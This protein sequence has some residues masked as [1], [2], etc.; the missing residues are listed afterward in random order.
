M[1][2]NCKIVV[3]GIFASFLTQSYL[4]AQTETYTVE[5]AP[6]SSKKY[7]EFSPVYYKNGIVFCANMNQ[8]LFVSYSTS[9]NKSLFKI[10]FVEPKE[11]NNWKSVELF[12]KELKS[13][14]NDGPVTFNSS[15][16]EIYFSRNIEENAGSGN[17]SRLRSRLGLFSSN[18]VNGKW[19]EIKEFRFNNEYYSVTTPSLSPDGKRI[20][21]ASDKPGGFGGSDLYY[22]DRLNDY[23]DNPVNLGPVIN[24]AGNESYP[25]INSA[26][27]LFFSSDGHA[28]LGGKDIFFSRFADSVWLAPVALD[29]PINSKWDDFGITTNPEMGEGYFSSNRGTKSLDIYYFKTNFQQQFYS[30]NQRENQYC[31]QFNDDKSVFLDSLYLVFEWDFGDGTKS[32]GSNVVHCF[33]GPGMYSVRQNILDKNTGRNLFTKLAYNLEIRDVE[34]PYINAVDLALVGDSIHI[35]GLK[36]NIPGFSI[37]NYSWDFGDGTRANGNAV[38]HTYSKEGE[39]IIKLGLSIKGDSTGIFKQLSVFKKI[40]TFEDSRLMLSF[41]DEATRMIKKVPDV[42]NYDHAF[43][44]NQYSAK[45]ELEKDAVFQ[46]EILSSKTSIPRE[47]N[48]FRNILNKYFVKEIYTEDNKTYSYIVCEEQNLIP[49]Y[50]AFNDLISLGYDDV[51]IKTAILTDP[52]EKELNSI[53]KVYSSSTDDLFRKDEARL[54]SDGLELLDQVAGLMKK[55]PGTKIVMEVHT[56]N[57]GPSSMNLL[58]SQ[59]RAQSLSIYLVSRGIDGERLIYKGYGDL[60]P[61]ALN[62]TPEERKKN[63]RVEFVL[64]NY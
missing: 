22:C 16:D 36:S 28:G 32:I 49:L 12:S 42:M 64:I 14:F 44:E 7:D 21:F 60:R 52:A 50:P 55:Y 47:S 45:T 5:L 58:M 2:G 46:L 17:V 29:P 61:I 25:F 51:K 24:T 27:E 23:W 53:K 11:K 62:N 39:Y 48:K 56:D 20:Y 4:L 41:E 1:S 38:Y 15:G 9:E 6:F 37:L 31:Y 10:L 40:R 43:I 8:D 3:L 18:L 13:D 34:Q 63:R 54:T 57:M 33:S 59:R 26:G 19:K 35:D 30:Y